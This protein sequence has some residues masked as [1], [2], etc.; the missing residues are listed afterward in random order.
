MRRFGVDH[1]E[2]LRL[3]RSRAQELRSDW[4][5]ANGVRNR[6]DRGAARA[7]WRLG[8]LLVVRAAVGR[9]LIGLGRRL[10]PG[11]GEPCG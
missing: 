10:E 5:I 3:A 11:E 7:D 1:Y 2:Q 6:N 8:F 4:R 9:T